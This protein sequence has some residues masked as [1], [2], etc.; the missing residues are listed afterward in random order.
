MQHPHAFEK[1]VEVIRRAQDVGIRGGT[2]W[3]L[4]QLGDTARAVAFLGDMAASSDPIAPSA[5]QYLS[6]DTGEA[7]FV[8]LRR[9]SETDAVVHPH[10]REHLEALASVRGWKR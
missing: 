5:I 1:L 8:V 6:M 7:G 9:L 4:T 10:A 3:T 2:L